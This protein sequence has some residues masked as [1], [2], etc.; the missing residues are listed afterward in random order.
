ME[1]GSW[2]YQELYKIVKFRKRK[3]W[4]EPVLNINSTLFPHTHPK[5]MLR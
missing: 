4:F 1:N 5:T 3:D 2:V